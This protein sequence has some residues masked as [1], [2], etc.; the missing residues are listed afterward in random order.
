MYPRFLYPFMA[1]N[2]NKPMKISSHLSIH[3]NNLLGAAA[4]V[5]R[6]LPGFDKLGAGLELGDCQ[7]KNPRDP[8]LP[9]AICLRDFS[10][11]QLIVLIY[12][13]DFGSKLNR[14][15]EDFV[16]SDVYSLM[17]S[18]MLGSTTTTIQFSWISNGIR[19]QMFPYNVAV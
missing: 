19:P 7:T 8:Q 12:V 10:Y 2:H 1:T 18:D 14:H 15:S 4:N 5:D 11:R 3:L 16:S 6:L 13:D 17:G 9:R